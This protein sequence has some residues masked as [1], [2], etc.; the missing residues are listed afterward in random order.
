VSLKNGEKA[1]V[2]QVPSKTVS[3]FNDLEKCPEKTVDQEVGDSNSPG[4]T[5]T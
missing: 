2:F 3:V 4:G 1:D 5:S